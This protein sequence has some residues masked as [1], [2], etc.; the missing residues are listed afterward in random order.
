M[1]AFGLLG[2]NLDDL[3]PLNRMVEANPVVCV[4]EL[5]REGL[6]TPGAE[7]RIE[8][9]DGHGGYHLAVPEAGKV[10]SDGQEIR[11]VPHPMC[12]GSIFVCG[13]DSAA[14]RLHRVDGVWRCRRCHRLEY[15]VR[16]R[17]RTIGNGKLNRVR[18][19]RRRIGASPVLFS[20]L[21]K[22]SLYARKHL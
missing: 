11:L 22:K 18:A 15:L 19:L 16:H 17:F 8:T 1:G 4:F 21:P 6:L 12:A 20:P 7:A 5:Y 14:Y 13:C 3:V 10:L 2:R 9:G